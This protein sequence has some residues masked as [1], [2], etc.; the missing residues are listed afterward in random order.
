M[1]MMFKQK[2]IMITKLKLYYS[3]NNNKIL[4]ANKRPLVLF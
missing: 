4:I 2:N 1:F 3:S